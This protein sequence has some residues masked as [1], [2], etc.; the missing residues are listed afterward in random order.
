[1]K[2]VIL[3]IMAV[4]I[5]F[6]SNGTIFAQDLSAGLEGYWAMN[7]GSGS[8]TSDLS[9]NG[10]NAA[11]ISGDPVW[12]DGIRGTALEFDGDD[13]LEVD[14]TGIGGDTPRT[15]TAW[16]K[17][18]A[19]N[20]EAYIGWGDE[21]PDGGKWHLLIRN[22]GLLRTAIAGSNI[23][24]TTILND[25]QWHFIAVVLVT[26]GF[27]AEDVF[28]YIDGE[29]EEVTFG[30]LDTII[31][32]VTDP[33][34]NAPNVRIGARRQGGDRFFIGAID[35][36]RMYSRELSI[37]EIQALMADAQTDVLDWELH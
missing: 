18:D 22:T 30:S 12:V 24:G 6:V 37:D 15:I 32:T 19:P 10:R 4:G 13:G 14:W 31:D 17:T 20:P 7:E 21:G 16:I 27:L 5:L 2:T 33:N 28:H 35:E 3:S 11:V 1:M 34:N 26:D 25:G 23:N 29:P 36:V 9:G 8:G